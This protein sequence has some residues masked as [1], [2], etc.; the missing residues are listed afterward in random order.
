[1]VLYYAA[2][3]TTGKSGD[4]AKKQRKSYQVSSFL[5]IKAWLYL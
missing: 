1:M 3:K 4:V 5:E 2:T